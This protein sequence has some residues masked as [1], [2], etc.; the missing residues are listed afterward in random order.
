MKRKLYIVILLALA[1]TLVNALGLGNLDLNSALN[2]PFD[3]RVHLL[4]PTADELDSLTVGLADS[5]AFARAKIDRPFILSNLKFSVRRSPDDGPDYI[6]V[7]S[8]E[9]IREPFLNFLVEVSWSNG[10]L[11]REY[12]VLLDPP[13]YDPNARASEFTRDQSTSYS[14]EP[15][16]EAITINDPDHQVV[17]TNDIEQPGSPA[18][19]S[20]NVDYSGGDYGPTEQADTLWSIASEMRPDSSISVNQMMSAL[21]RANPEAFF[22]QN[23]NGLKR[24]QILRM[25]TESEI[26][27][28][29]NAQAL[30]EVQ[31]Q[32][33]AWDGIKDNLS[34]A[35][36]ERPE[37][38]SVPE[39]TDTTSGEATESVEAAVDSDPELK[40]VAAEETGEATQQVA[41]VD[42]GQGEDLIL[43]QESIQALTH[44]NMELKDRL[45]ES[46]AL[47][48]DL[49]RLLSLKDDE[50][51]AL[52]GQVVEDPDTIDEVVDSVD[53]EMVTEVETVLED[54]EDVLEDIEEEA[55][56]EGTAMNVAEDEML[57]EDEEELETI[58]E[59]EVVEVIETE[60]ASSSAGVMGMIDQ[61]LGPVKDILL[62]NPMIGMAVAGVFVLLI[63]IIVIMKF[64]KEPAETIDIDAMTEEAFPDFDSGDLGATGDE[65]PDSEAVTVLPPDSEAETAMPEASVDLDIEEEAAAPIVEEALIEE[66][67]DEDPMQEVNTYLAFEQFDQA[68][69]FVRNAINDTPDNAEY[70]TKLLEVF[71]TSGNKK[72]YEEEAKILHDKFGEANEHWNMAVAMWS[73]MSP[74]RALFEEGGDEEDDAADNTG[75]FVDVTADDEAGKDDAGLDFDIGGAE[76]PAADEGMLDLTASDEGEGMLDITASDEGEDMLDV[77]A[78]VGLEEVDEVANNDSEDVLDISSTGGDDL[79]DLTAGEESSGD[80]LLD[81]TSAANLD[82]DSEEDLL[83][84]TA[85]T[86][87]GAD[88][89]ELLGLNIEPESESLEIDIPDEDESVEL[90][91]D[92]AGEAASAETPASDDD[93]M[94]DFDLG[95]NDEDESIELDVNEPED[96]GLE[97]E[98]GLPES[99][100]NE[101]EDAGLDIGL[102][103]PEEDEPIRLDAED[104]DEISLD[105]DMGEDEGI[106][107]DLSAEANDEPAE[108]DMDA[109]SEIETVQVDN[110]DMDFELTMDDTPEVSLEDEESLNLDETVEIPK[111]VDLSVDDDDDDDDEHT[112]FVP[113]AAQPEEQTAEDEIATKLDLAKAYVELGDKDSAK[114]ILDEVIADGNDEQRK[115]AEDLLAQV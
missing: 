11:F 24:G 83:D 91:M 8:Q 81:V 35:V 93:N 49:K 19:T 55:V 111:S 21:L 90:D 92:A 42:S 97:M 25:P 72:S 105:F 3:A 43:A 44:E 61:Y 77:T 79:L 30:A 48:E 10:R 20:P 1:P 75:G 12:T 2:E 26:N 52:Q 106:E 95:S 18:A 4:S 15:V 9:P 59:D 109:G 98:L 86:S 87:A 101:A 108:L 112:V 58:D 46:E 99:G 57:V 76:E 74:N 16:V 29:S 96:A 88:S 65:V 104:E 68:E 102:D 103:V 7:F 94:L 107:L 13:L 50:L 78:A 34:N 39:S 54:G 67:S 14:A 63:L 82:L 38:S 69:E 17:Y 45:Q 100:S 66:E 40:L 56:E 64:R 89:S 60:P 41:S 70:H 32:H 110:S 27:A 113:R 31:S 115:Q 53:E 47:L 5:E 51:A 73:E 84:V 85:A 28:L 22:N 23:I 114:T 33:A 71:Y 80:D 6:R 36:N 37:V 62:G